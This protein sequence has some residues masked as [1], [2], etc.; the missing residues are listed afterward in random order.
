[1]NTPLVTTNPDILGGTPVF[2]GTRVPVTVL[3]EN[4][5]GGL[6]L[7]EIL[8]SNPTLQRE[9]AI[10]ALNQAEKLLCRKKNS[11][12]LK[13]N[14]L[15]ILKCASQFLSAGEACIAGLKEE[16][17]ITQSGMSPPDKIYF[18][19]AAGIVNLALAAE[20]HLKAIKGIE[21]GQGTFD[22]GHKLKDLF[23]SLGDDSKNSIRA[24]MDDKDFD[25]HLAAMSDAF[26]VWRY[27]FEEKHD[28]KLDDDSGFLYRFAW[29]TRKRAE[30]LP[31]NF[32]PNGS[33]WTA[34]TL[35]IPLSE[36]IWREGY[37]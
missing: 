23:N 9:Q 16:Y 17:A 10:E 8:D 33:T 5:A 21:N 32:D 12:Q 26:E 29:V 35:S 20:H 15:L 19:K 24:S 11:E 4:L 3:F 37:L 36:T 34:T 28:G 1:M 31:S 18:L 22:F 7:D 13:G 30:S 6:C 25:K 27:V 14:P 2:A